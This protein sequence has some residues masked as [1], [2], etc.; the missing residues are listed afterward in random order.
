MDTSA[1]LHSLQEGKHLPYAE[2]R[3]SIGVSACVCRHCGEEIKPACRMTESMSQ[4]L[5]SSQIFPAL[6]RKT[7]MPS[8]LIF[9]PVAGKPIP[10]WVL[11]PDEVQ[12]TAT[13]SRSARIWLT[14]TLMSGKALRSSLA[15]A[16]SSS[17][18]YA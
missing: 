11:V 7:V 5:H 14:S 9:L 13:R 18:V 3:P 17:R 8:I 1:G 16:I 12:Y 4:T 6:K 2:D 15:A 10:A